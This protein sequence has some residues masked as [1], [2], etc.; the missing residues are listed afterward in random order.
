MQTHELVPAAQYLRMSTEHQQYSMQNQAA[1][2]D[3]YAKQNNFIVT[4]TYQDAGKSGL[5]FKQRRGLCALLNE[6]IHGEPPFKAILVY[7]VSRWG[8]FQDSDEAAH[9]E[10]LCRSAGVPVHYCAEQFTND[11]SLPSSIMKALKRTMAAEYSRELGVKVYEGKKRLVLLGFRAGGV[12]GYGLRRMLISADGRPKQQLQ[13]GEYKSLSSDRIILVPGP[14]R[15]VECVRE[16]F[17]MALRRKTRA[18]IA[19]ELNRR[20]VPWVDGKSWNFDAVTHLLTNPKYTGRNQWGRTTQKLRTPTLRNPIEK[21]VI[22]PDAFYAIIDKA[23]F[24]SVQKI[25]SDRI[26][27]NTEM[28]RGLK[29]LLAKNGRLS[30][31]L[32]DN[33]RTLP[34]ITAY[35]SRFGGIREIYKLIGYPGQPGYLE[36]ANRAKNTRRL[37][38][39]VIQKI[40]TNFPTHF[41][42]TTAQR[43]AWRPMLL[44]D[45]E[46]R[47]S[48]YVCPTLRSEYG[49]REW[50]VTPVR[51]EKPYMALLCL[52]N[53]RNEDFSRFYLFPMISLCERLRFGKQGKFLR[54]GTR[55]PSLAELYQAIKAMGQS[56][57]HRT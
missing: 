9:Y 49:K 31:S 38:R 53:R 7:D 5:I 22:K 14:K 13:S 48:V 21:R 32:I 8:R 4:Q 44:I 51:W 56:L 37:H 20:G 15:E 35:R 6:V 27:S 17:Q 47:L 18:W 43:R 29:R 39:E 46:I 16:I 41:S 45:S 28:L 19:R 11:G 10:F 36:R 1:A 52:L 42:I 12:V 55:V 50:A 54:R 30:E 34:S 25:H 2:I 3:E 57:G 40:V 24:D 23:V 26:K 33:A